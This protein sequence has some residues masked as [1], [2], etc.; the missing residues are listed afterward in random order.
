MK[1]FQRKIIRP[2]CQP[3]DFLGRSLSLDE[4]VRGS[5]ESLSL[6]FEKQRESSRHSCTVRN[7]VVLFKQ[8]TNKI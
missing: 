6:A 3:Y 2:T 5:L 1:D 4:E 7:L 8:H